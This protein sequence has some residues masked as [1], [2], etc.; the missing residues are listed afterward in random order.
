MGELEIP[1]FASNL[2]AQKQGGSIGIRK[3][4]CVAIPLNQ[5]E[6]LV[7]LGGVDLEPGP[8]GLVNR[9]HLGPGP[10]D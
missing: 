7:E 2:R 8:E 3:P 4:G 9:F 1:S 10:A 5:R 6:L